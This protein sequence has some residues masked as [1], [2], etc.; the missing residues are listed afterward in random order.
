M[1][2]DVLEKGLDVVFVGTAA[3]TRSAAMGAY[4]AHPGNRFW[5][6]LHETGL[7]PH[8]FEPHDFRDLLA[9]GIGATDLCKTQSGG[10]HMIDDYDLEGFAKKMRHYAPRC[11]AFTSKTGGSLW[12]GCSTK[13]IAAREQ[14]ILSEGFPAVFVL[15]SPSGR[16]GGYWSIEPWRTLAR[17]L[18]S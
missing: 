17:W 3:G 15:P 14:P 9:L 7:T 8:R 18:R 4:Y 13:D 1:L 12:L 2:P 10:D 6:T 11:I 16:A 5:R